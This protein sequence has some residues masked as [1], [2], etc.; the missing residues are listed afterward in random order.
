MSNSCEGRRL[1]IS[2]SFLALTPALKLASPSTS[3][4]PQSSRS[5]LVERIRSRPPFTSSNTFPRVAIRGLGGTTPAASSRYLWICRRETVTL[6]LDLV[7]V[8]AFSTV[9][10]F[11]IR[12]FLPCPAGSPFLQLRVLQNLQDLHPAPCLYSCAGE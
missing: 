11:A 1:T 4:T 9:D 10:L 12:F 7:V 3:Q 6:D 8:L 5:R 2:L